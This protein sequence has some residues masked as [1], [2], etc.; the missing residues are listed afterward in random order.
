MRDLSQQV[1]LRTSRQW[2]YSRKDP[3]CDPEF[4]LK[5]RSHGPAWA[6]TIPGWTER[7]AMPGMQG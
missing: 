4:I 3:A 7:D 5:A 1:S 2:G 6:G